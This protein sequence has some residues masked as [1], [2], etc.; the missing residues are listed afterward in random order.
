MRSWPTGALLTL[1]VAT[2]R[3]AL[4]ALVPQRLVFAPKD[5]DG[6]RV[7]DFSGVAVL[8]RLLSGIVMPKALVAP[9]GF[10][11]DGM[12][13]SRDL[14]GINVPK[15]PCVHTRRGRRSRDESYDDCC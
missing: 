9:T 2:A 3:Q 12:D 6:E 10:E 7:Y 11:P 8:D 1:N 14:N 5:L 13:S 4:R 15:S